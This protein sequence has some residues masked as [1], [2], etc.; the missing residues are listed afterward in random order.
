MPQRPSSLPPRVYM[1]EKGITIWSNRGVH[2]MPQNPVPAFIEGLW[3][4]HKEILELKRY[5]GK[6][7]E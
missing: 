7:L 1:R 4:D 2:S 6:L 3:S 5:Y